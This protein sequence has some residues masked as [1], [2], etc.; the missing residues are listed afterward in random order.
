M[1]HNVVTDPENE[2]ASTWPITCCGGLRASAVAPN[3]WCSN[4]LVTIASHSP[5]PRFRR[6]NNCIRLLRNFDQ[7]PSV[8]SCLRTQ[9]KCRSLAS[10]PRLDLG[11][12][13]VSVAC[14]KPC[15]LGG[16]LTDNYRVRRLGSVRHNVRCSSRPR[17]IGIIGCDSLQYATIGSHFEPV[18]L[19]PVTMCAPPI[20][21]KRRS[22]GIRRRLALPAPNASEGKQP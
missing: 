13:C 21:T 6:C 8:S 20:A 19:W 4:P 15:K 5:T 18:T 3:Q 22:R 14:C 7:L 11:L 2:R 1:R 12:E 10:K 17:S 9:V 16:S